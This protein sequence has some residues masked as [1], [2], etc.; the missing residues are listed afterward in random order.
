MRQASIALN[1]KDLH[2]EKRRYNSLKS[3]SKMVVV[4]FHGLKNKN[5]KIIFETCVMQI[6]VHDRLRKVSTPINS[7]NRIPHVWFPWRPQTTTTGEPAPTAILVRRLLYKWH[8]MS[9]F[10]DGDRRGMTP[11]PGVS[12]VGCPSEKNRM[13]CLIHVFDTSVI[14]LK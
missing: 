7:S 12:I 13:I 11:S 2:L 1:E 3:L 4:P 5:L 6:T 8:F 9:G 14:I 10:L